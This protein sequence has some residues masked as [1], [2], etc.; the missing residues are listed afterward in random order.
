[1]LW[2]TTENGSLG[3]M[4]P[5]HP[6]IRPRTGQLH[7]RTASRR[8]V[9]AGLQQAISSNCGRVS[10]PRSVL[11]PHETPTLFCFASAEKE[12]LG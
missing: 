3:A 5:P 7:R 12:V 11:G 10:S 4:S 1:M 8:D 6:L 9:R 2:S